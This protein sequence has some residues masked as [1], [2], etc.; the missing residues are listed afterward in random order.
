MS[1]RDQANCKGVD[2]LVFLPRE[3]LGRNATRAAHITAKRY[4][5]ECPQETVAACLE[6]ALAN[7]EWWGVWGNTTPRQRRD[8]REA[9]LRQARC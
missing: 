7:D 5:E 3:S 8:I 9:R 6:Y 4:C 2:P 1:W